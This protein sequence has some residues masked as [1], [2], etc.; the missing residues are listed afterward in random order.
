MSTTINN[1]SNH[2]NSSDQTGNITESSKNYSY[3]PT[4]LAGCISAMLYLMQVQNQCKKLY[5]EQIQTEIHAQEMFSNEA[6]NALRDQGNNAMMGAI[7]QGSGQVLHGAMQVG[8]G[9]A[10][11]SR[12]T[13]EEAEVKTPN[14]NIEVSEE[15]S[16]NRASESQVKKEESLQKQSE[17]EK[18]KTKTRTRHEVSRASEALKGVGS[19]FAGIG[20]IA[21]GI[22]QSKEKYRAA[23]ERQAEFGQSVAK[24]MTDQYFQELNSVSSDI[25]KVLSQIESIS[26]AGTV[27]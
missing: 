1:Q 3:Q 25:Q 9:F 4:S 12:T 16:Q 23:D 19:A 22:Y 24:T 10:M 7:M 21:Q 15:A 14:R 20:T 2:T 18:P 6:A 17:L 11:S 27:K 13:T 5:A 8:S 26:S